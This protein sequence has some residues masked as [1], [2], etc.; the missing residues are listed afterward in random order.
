MRQIRE[1]DI[2]TDADFQ[3]FDDK[4]EPE[5]FSALS[6]YMIIDAF[7][8]MTEL[9]R[10]ILKLKMREKNISINEMS[11]RTRATR[12]KITKEY[13]EL[14]RLHPIIKGVEMAKIRQTDQ[15][16]NVLNMVEKINDINPD[17]FT[18]LQ[19]IKK[20]CDELRCKYI[21]CSQCKFLQIGGYC[22]RT[23]CVR[24]LSDPSCPLFEVKK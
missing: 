6:M 21:K 19:K 16:I 13:D 12:A 14:I 20:R 17:N 7:V 9:Q 3:F 18:T 2:I 22:E 8:N 24:S 23:M 15:I 1:T 10:Q 4:K 5:I 11:K